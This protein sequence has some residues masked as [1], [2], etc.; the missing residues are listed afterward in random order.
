MVN[1]AK[2][3]VT[4]GLK[5]ETLRPNVLDYLRKNW[6]HGDLALFCHD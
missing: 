2:L 4:H 1:V 5:T 6:D 3:Q